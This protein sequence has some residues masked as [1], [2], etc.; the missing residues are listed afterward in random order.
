MEEFVRVALKLI[1]G[2]A[3]VGAGATL[4]KKGAQEAVKVKLPKPDLS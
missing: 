2:S 4:L 1:L 3:I